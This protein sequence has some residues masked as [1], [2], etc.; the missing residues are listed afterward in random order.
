MKLQR[1]FLAAV[2][3]LAFLA[4]AFGPCVCVAQTWDY[5]EAQGQ[6]ICDPLPPESYAVFADGSVEKIV[7]GA[8]LSQRVVA[9]L[10]IVNAKVENVD[11]S[12]STILGGSFDQ[13]VLVRCNFAGAFLRGGFCDNYTQF[14]DCVFDD[15]LLDGFNCDALSAKQLKKTRNFKRPSSLAEAISGK[16]PPERLYMRLYDVR[17]ADL[18]FSFAYLRGSYRGLSARQLRQTLDFHHKIY[19]ELRV[20]VSGA[21]GAPLLDYRDFDFSRS[22]FVECQFVDLDFTGADFTDAAFHECSLSG[23]G[24]TLE[25]MKSTWNWKAGR[26][27]LLHLPP[28]LQAQIPEEKR[29]TM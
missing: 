1:F 24:L 20:G 19:R 11:F 2:A 17:C 9:S 28:E 22:S 15:A 8:N 26:M 6:E 10:M 21:P 27:D 25:Q 29:K 13:A 16:F 7:D 18:D 3:T 12:G 23:R 14:V 4:S 5:S